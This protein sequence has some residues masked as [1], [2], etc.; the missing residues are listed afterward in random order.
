MG[1][2]EKFTF[3]MD[4]MSGDH[5]IYKEVFETTMAVMSLITAL[6]LLLVGNGIDPVSVVAAFLAGL[7]P[8]STDVI[9]AV[10]E[11]GMEI[12]GF[13]GIQSMVYKAALKHKETEW[14]KGHKEQLLQGKWLHIHDKGNVRIG[15]VEIEQNFTQ[16]KVKGFNINP[17]DPHVAN[18]GR[19]NWSYI[20]C[21]LYPRELTSIEFFGSYAARKSDGTINQGIHIFHTMDV[22]AETGLPVYLNGNFCDS[23]RVGESTVADINDRKGEIHLFRMTPAL[24]EVI[25]NKKGINYECLGDI[26]H[27]E[28]LEDE[29]FIQTLKRVVA[30]CTAK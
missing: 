18:K 25:Y 3:H 13:F 10:I 22:S 27:Q 1:K 9:A 19:T 17:L 5:E 16:L 30:K 29:P 6:Y 4:E 14:A 20:T 2:K 15:V 7:I 21:K 23:F 28:G 24:E 11:G 12:A 26:L 8:T